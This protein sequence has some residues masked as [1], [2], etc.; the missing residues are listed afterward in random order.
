M[1][2]SAYG[3]EIVGKVLKC[4]SSKSVKEYQIEYTWAD[5]GKSYLE[6]CCSKDRNQ[7][8]DDPLV[9]EPEFASSTTLVPEE[10]E[11]EA[12][13]SAEMVG[14][15]AVQKAPEEKEEANVKMEIDEEVADAGSIT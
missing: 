13:A 3:I 5:D 12:E 15:T 14:L 4:G 2:F 8:P 7:L 11:Q 10:P 1:R 9:A 6:W